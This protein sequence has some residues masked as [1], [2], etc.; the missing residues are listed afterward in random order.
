MERYKETESDLLIACKIQPNNQNYQKDLAGCYFDE[1]KFLEAI[2]IYT[3]IIEKTKTMHSIWLKRGQAYAKI[4][5][6]YEAMHDLDK[7]IKLKK[8]PS[9]AT[10]QRAK[11]F[12]L[13]GNIQ[14]AIMD[15]SI[16]IQNKSDLSFGYQYR[17]FCYLLKKQYKS[18]IEDE[19]KAIEFA[20][21]PS[22]PHF[23]LGMVHLY[24]YQMHFWKTQQSN[25]EIAEQAK[26]AFLKISKSE[27]S[28]EK[29]RTGS[30]AMLEFLNNNFE[31]AHDILMSLIG[32][33]DVSEI[34]ISL[35]SQ[36]SRPQSIFLEC[37]EESSFLWRKL[38]SQTEQ[39]PELISDQNFFET[40]RDFI[41]LK[42]YIN[43]KTLADEQLYSFICEKVILSEIEKYSENIEEKPKKLSNAVKLLI[44]IEPKSKG[45]TAA[46]IC[47]SLDVIYRNILERDV[48]DQSI[49]EVL[50]YFIY[51]QRQDTNIPQ[52]GIFM[53]LIQI[54][55]KTE[56]L[57]LKTIL[58]STLNIFEPSFVG[59][60][61][62][63][64]IISKFLEI[65]PSENSEL[66]VL[67]CNLIFK[68][69]DN[70]M[71]ETQE[72][73]SNYLISFLENEKAKESPSIQA[74]GFYIISLANLS[75]QR[76]SFEFLEKFQ[77][78]NTKFST[79]D[80]FGIILLYSAQKIFFSMDIFSVD[81]I[82]KLFAFCLKIWSRSENLNNNCIR[83]METCY[84]KFSQMQ[85]DQV[86]K[87]FEQTLEKMLSFAENPKHAPDFLFG[88]AS[89]F[90]RFYP[91][92]DSQFSSQIVDQY[93]SKSQLLLENKNVTE[94]DKL[95]II[96]SILGMISKMNQ[97]NQIQSKEILE[98]L[99]V[100]NEI[101][102][103]IQKKLTKRTG[104]K[105]FYLLFFQQKSI[106]ER[107]EF[108]RSISYLSFCETENIEIRSYSKLVLKFWKLSSSKK[109]KFECIE[110]LLHLYFAQECCQ[111]VQELI[112]SILM[113]ILHQEKTQKGKIFLFNRLRSTFINN[114]IW[115][116]I[117]QR[118]KIQET[119]DFSLENLEDSYWKFFT[120]SSIKIK[121]LIQTKI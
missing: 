54:L 84:A 104:K 74:I 14:K 121:N 5:R 61:E 12:L 37:G 38:V 69:K 17:G 53:K 10:Y 65:G 70:C 4:G 35:R 118:Y 46:T 9:F 62:Q 64:S 31:K 33:F 95:I 76:L 49:Y 63:E 82:E 81:S 89:F 36:S 75:P 22:E 32:K 101:K 91:R 44:E 68:W 105:A 47:K 41:G 97:K 96:I 42:K 93:L 16:T 94:H 6:Y 72:K 86:I 108:I 106:Q 71:P 25:T 90:V 87:F 109:E 29:Y 78:E 57:N 85:T 1:N 111:E 60:Y 66:N 20:E 77:T 40:I 58:L 83:T 15:F 113:K 3:S 98:N 59:I 19:K 115:E 92:L 55:G 2:Q 7:A 99:S 24:Q 114:D 88:F 8:E 67:L 27:K 56:N 23:F 48:V 119:H 39:N 107:I 30:Q 100:S 112:V 51:T 50:N 11:V 102:N 43:F 34:I 28:N 117:N 116:K 110:L 45:F 103:L 120:T 21:D 79:S 52:N 18:A 26:I 13:M 80:F 73:I